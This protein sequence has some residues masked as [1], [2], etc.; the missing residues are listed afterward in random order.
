MSKVSTEGVPTEK[1]SGSRIR[2]WF[3]TFGAR[4]LASFDVST[5]TE[6]VTD[7]TSLSGV[8]FNPDS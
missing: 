2:E 7:L 3:T 4:V 5:G 1:P 6:L 8:P